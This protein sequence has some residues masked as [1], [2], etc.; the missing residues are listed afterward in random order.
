M[1][2]FRGF[3]DVDDVAAA[4]RCPALEMVTSLP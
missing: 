3:H 1:L 2:R 4:L